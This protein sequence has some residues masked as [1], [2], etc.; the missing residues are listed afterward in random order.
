MGLIV[1]LVVNALALW[2]AT[3]VVPGLGFSGTWVSML[4]VALVFGLV[5]ALVRPALTMLTCP[6]VLL[7]LGL[8]TLVINALMLMLTG[9]LSERMGLGFT[10]DGFWAAFLGAI[11]VSV[12]SVAA[13]LMLG[14]KPASATYRSWARSFA[15]ETSPRSTTKLSACSAEAADGFLEVR[16]ASG[17]SLS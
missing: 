3:A 2:V 10:V 15:S 12:V 7:T 8:F 5:N 13:T 14:K 16:S 4:G 1:R 9:W 17:A 6:L 11:V